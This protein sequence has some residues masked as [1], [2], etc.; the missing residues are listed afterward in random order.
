MTRSPA[1]PNTS[2]A[3]PVGHGNRC[4]RVIRLRQT[5]PAAL[6]DQNV[7]GPVLDS[8]V[9]N[10]NPQVR[11]IHPR[12]TAPEKSVG[13]DIGSSCSRKSK[14]RAAGNCLF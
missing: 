1:S 8:A 6:V 12:I 9:E 11:K 3:E 13:Q 10:P 14:L 5:R 4:R 7:S 2:V